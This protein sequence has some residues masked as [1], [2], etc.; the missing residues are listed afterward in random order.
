[1]NGCFRI[2]VESEKGD[3]A[4]RGLSPERHAFLNDELMGVI[5]CN[6]GRDTSEGFYVENMLTTGYA[7]E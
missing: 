7:L 2:V 6:L 1:M 5:F 3:V 4:I